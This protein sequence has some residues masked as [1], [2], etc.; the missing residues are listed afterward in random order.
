MPAHKTWILL[1]SGWL[2]GIV[3]LYTWQYMPAYHT[4]QHQH[5]IQNLPRHIAIIMDG[6]RRW[7]KSRGLPAW[8][9]HEQGVQPLKDVIACCIEHGIPYLSVYAFSA[10]NFKRPHEEQQYLF[11]TISQRLVHDELPQLIE[12]GVKVNIIGDQTQFP[13]SLRDDIAYVHQQT[14][15]NTTLALNILFCYS[16]RN[17]IA[18]ATKAI[19]KLYAD[20]D[21]ASEDINAETISRHLLTHDIPDPDMVI[22]TGNRHRISNFLLYQMAYSEIYFI[23]QY[24]PN[25]TKD[26]I[27]E[28]LQQFS[29]TNRT[30]GG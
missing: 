27:V 10:E 13:A 19:S 9:G 26:D 24:W 28:V 14:A 8:I 5:T 20:G 4:P 23:P 6:N 30:F 2:A 16:G 25:I 1:I 17:D 29:A 21:I 18:Q 22:R 11:N 15:D 7:A 12:Q 3:S